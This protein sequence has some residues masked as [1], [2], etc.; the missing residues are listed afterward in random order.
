MPLSL[1]LPLCKQTAQDLELTLHLLQLSPCLTFKPLALQSGSHPSC[2]SLV[3]TQEVQSF[4]WQCI[5]WP[6]WQE[7]LH[8][9]QERVHLWWQPQ[10]QFPCWISSKRGVPFV[11]A[12]R[13]SQVAESDNLPLISGMLRVTVGAIFH[14][15]S[16]SLSMKPSPYPGTVRWHWQL[17][18]ALASL[19]SSSSI[20]P[21]IQHD[22]E[23]DSESDSWSGVAESGPESVTKDDYL[24]CSDTED[25]A[26]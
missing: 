17:A 13:K 12:K 22:A 1:W 18:T 24:T 11:G 7:G 3:P 4:L 15:S 16:V 23:S 20:S 8:Q 14:R 10:I 25:A 26:V 21:P 19:N 2:S 9:N 6:T 5:W